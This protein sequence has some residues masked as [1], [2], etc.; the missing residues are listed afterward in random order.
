MIT[1]QITGHAALPE[2]PPVAPAASPRSLLLMLVAIA[3]V[4]SLPGLFMGLHADDWFQVRPR[5]FSQSLATFVGDWNEGAR[6]EGGFYRPLSRLSFTL[7]EALHGS[8]AVGCHI[9]NIV[10]FVSAIVGVFLTCQM[11]CGQTTGVIAAACAMLIALNPLKNEALFWV[12]GRTDLLAAA[13]IIHAVAF[14]LRALAR[15]SIPIALASLAFLVLA[16]LSKEVAVSG[17]II[18]PLAALLLA[19]PALARSRARA[20]LMIL[21]VGIGIAYLSFRSA[22]LGGIAGYHTIQPHTVGTLGGNIARIFSALACPFQAFP[23]SIFSLFWAVAGA[24]FCGI[25][26]FF[27]GFRRAPVFC[28]LAAILSSLP[29]ATITVSPL[30]GMRVLFLP[31]LFFALFII[32]TFCHRDGFAF[33]QRAFLVTV[34]ILTLMLQVANVALMAQMTSAAAKNNSVVKSANEFVAAAPDGSLLVIPEGRRLYR[35]R[36]LD[37][38]A[39]L[40]AAVQTCWLRGKGHSADYQTESSPAK[41]LIVLRDGTKSVSIAPN[42]QPWMN[43]NVTLLRVDAALALTPTRLDRSALIDFPPDQRSISLPPRGG[44]EILVHA[45]EQSLP[46]ASEEPPLVATLA[47]PEPRTLPPLTLPI[48]D[49]SVTWL[50]TTLELDAPTTVTLFRPTNPIHESFSL[51]SIGIASYRSKIAK[52]EK[53]SS[54]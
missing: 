9:T 10:I 2:P 52:K 49:R 38:G 33:V 21:P 50:D 25:V 41:A 18:L 12:S 20:M 37:P 8:S 16:L 28:L 46:R 23:A 6:G 7:D 35:Q 1:V 53:M 51:R 30:D 39:T 3:V 5:T 43:E 13:F 45:I 54:P 26:L 29:M 31:L 14:A 19:P 34:A 40:Y 27:T 42:L 47:G 22:V 15:D 11:L 44:D 24:A 4:V 17:C 48:G 36:I 32:T